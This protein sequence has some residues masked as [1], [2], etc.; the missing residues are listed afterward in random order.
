MPGLANAHSH[1][2][3]RAL[4]GITQADRGT[5]WTWRERMYAGGGP[6]RSGQ[7]P[8]AGHRRLRRDGAGRH[9][10][11]RASSTTC[12][13]AR[14]ARGTPTQRDGPGAD[15]GG[16]PGGHADHPAGHLL[17]VGR[18]GRRTAGPQALAG[19]QLRFGDGDARELGGAG[20]RA[21]RRLPGSLARRRGPAPPSTQCAPC[22]R[23]RCTRWWPGRTA[24]R[25]AAR[26]PIRAGGR[27]RG[28]RRR[29]PRAP[30][31]RCSTRPA[32][33]ARA[34]HRGARHPPERPATSS[35][36]AAAGPSPASARP[37]R[38]T[39]PTGS[40]RPGALPTAGS[41]LTLGSDSQAVIDLFEEARRVELASGWPPR[42][43][44]ISPQSRWPAAA[45]LDGHA[46]LGWPEA[47][48]FAA[49][50]LADLVHRRAGLTAAGRDAW[51]R[52]RPG[53][54]HLR[55]RCRRRPQRR[56]RRPRGGA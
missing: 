42:S 53:V 20:R 19:P 49:G 15:R 32:R 21:R 8:G 38:P 45:T 24:G 18:L 27:E 51:P 34:V 46:S 39:W 54:G 44:A 14:A 11:R 56:D 48:E 52:P 50:A 31:P 13:T 4:R 41:P 25:A 2:F 43:A 36:S 3:H 7:L 23:R 37:P 10:L 16:A 47:G 6:P 30:R 55:G 28:M 40:A 33:S 35:C 1:A 29:L 22:R 17:P 12:T 9:H 26:A 5:F